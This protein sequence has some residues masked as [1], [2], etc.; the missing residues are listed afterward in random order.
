MGSTMEDRKGIGDVDDLIKDTIINQS[1]ANVPSSKDYS[2]GEDSWFKADYEPETSTTE[3]TE[4][5]DGLHKA[6]KSQEYTEKECRVPNL[7]EKST[8]SNSEKYLVSEENDDIEVIDV[9]SHD[10]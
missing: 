9:I 3:T 10:Q 6:Y 5:E 7:K 8:S 4:E 1:E 2:D